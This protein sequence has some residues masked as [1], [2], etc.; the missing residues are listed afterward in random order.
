VRWTSIFFYNPFFRFRF[1]ETTSSW[2]P[3]LG[4]QSGGTLCGDQFCDASSAI[5]RRYVRLA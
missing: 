4:V 2:K 1:N 5:A 3:S